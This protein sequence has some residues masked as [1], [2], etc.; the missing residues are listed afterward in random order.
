MIWKSTSSNKKHRTTRGTPDVFV[1][2]MG[3]GNH[4]MGFEF[5]TDKGNSYPEQIALQEIEAVNVIRSLDDFV[6]ATKSLLT[7]NGKVIK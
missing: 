6:R 7:N 3:K 5:K 2:K 4:W 1:T